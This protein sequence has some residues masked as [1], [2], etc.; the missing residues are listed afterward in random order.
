M[1]LYL[2]IYFIGMIA[3][4]LTFYSVTDVD[5]SHVLLIVSIF[6]PFVVYIAIGEGVKVVIKYI[7]TKV[8]R[9][10][11]SVVFNDD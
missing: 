9:D 4:F 2:G 8:S 6:W 11:T 3:M 7:V 5:E 1:L 10:K